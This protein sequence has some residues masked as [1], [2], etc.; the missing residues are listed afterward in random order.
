MN[1]KALSGEQFFK[2]VESCMNAL[3][4]NSKV[5]N[6]Q[7]AWLSICARECEKAATEA[8]RIFKIAL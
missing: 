6:Y 8:I 3:N 7:S 5:L 1:G 2:F 4:S